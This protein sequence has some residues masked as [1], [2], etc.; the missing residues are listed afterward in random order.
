MQEYFMC[1]SYGR[2]LIFSSVDDI[3]AIQESRDPRIFEKLNDPSCYNN[4]K[5]D[6]NYPPITT[7][8]VKTI[9]LKILEG[10]KEFGFKVISPEEV[11]ILKNATPK[12]G[13]KCQIRI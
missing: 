2:L 5:S 6:P 3:L 10:C 4:M 1:Q 12:A 8:E 7:K 9:I 11:K 13:C